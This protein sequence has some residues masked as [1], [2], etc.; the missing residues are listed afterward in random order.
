MEKSRSIALVGFM[1]SGKTTIGRLLAEDLALDFVDLDILIEKTEA[2]TIAMI[3]KEL[4]EDYFRMLETMMLEKTVFMQPSVVACG[5]GIVERYENRK[6]LKENF[7]VVYLKAP[8]E[9]CY[10]RISGDLS[11]PKAALSKDELKKLYR[12]RSPLYLE[13]AHHVINVENKNPETIVKAIK[14]ELQVE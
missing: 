9:L 2:K 4:G 10:Q 12:K 7:I 1:G 8:F 13:V 3:F 5:G 6:I 14:G 11:R